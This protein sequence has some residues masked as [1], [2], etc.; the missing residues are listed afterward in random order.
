MIVIFV[1]KKD[2]PVS[3]IRVFDF[4]KGGWGGAGGS[5]GWK[6]WVEG[7][8]VAGGVGGEAGQLITMGVC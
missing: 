2:R 6:E 4:E 1:G 8:E 7:V 3:F 5:C